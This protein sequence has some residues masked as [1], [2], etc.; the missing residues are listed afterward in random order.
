MANQANAMLVGCHIYLILMFAYT[1]IRLMV[2]VNVVSLTIYL[3]NFFWS[4]M[5]LW[6][7]FFSAYTEIL[8]HIILA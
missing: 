2:W 6:N 1:Q 3:A 7:Y 5:N 8:V 4:K